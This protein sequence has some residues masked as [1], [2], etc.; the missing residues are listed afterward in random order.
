MQS[1][2][3]QAKSLLFGYFFLRESV[4]IFSFVYRENCR[5]GE[6]GLGGNHEKRRT[7][8]HGAGSAARDAGEGGRS[9]G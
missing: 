2:S 3:E 1:W 8:Q 4:W 7:G 5:A 6:L 9:S